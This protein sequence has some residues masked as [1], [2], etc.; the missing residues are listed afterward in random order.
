MLLEHWGATPTE[1]TAPMPGDELI[2]APAMSATRSITL[3]ADRDEVFGWLAQMGFGKAGWYSYDLID[4]LGRRSADR[5]H[6]HWQVDS[7]GD[8]VP[9]GPL[10]FTVT[11]L[12]RPAHLVLALLDRRAAGHVI[13]FT[14]AYRLDPLTDRAGTRLVSRAR[15]TVAGPLGRPLSAALTVGDGVMVRR[16][17]LGLAQ[18]CGRASR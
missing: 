3:A 6:P 8:E 1:V 2:D 12:D 18:R 13:D 7:V 17:L 4:N 15:A 5:L 10:A 9:G 11:H 14:L 16:Q